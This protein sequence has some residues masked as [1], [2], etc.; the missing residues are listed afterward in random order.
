MWH[1]AVITEL[2]DF[3]RASLAEPVTAHVVEEPQV[4]RRRRVVAGLGY[5]VGTIALAATLR[6]EAGDELFYPAALGLAAIW[7]VGA[8]LAGP[9]RLGSARTRAGGVTTPVIQPFALGALLVVLFLAGAAVVAGIP[10]LREPVDDLLDHARYGSL[11]IVLALTLLNGVVEEL[12]FR[13][14][15]F[16]AFAPRHAVAGTT[17]LYTLTTIGSGVPLLVLAAAVLGFV[18]A[19]QRR[20]TGGVLAPI[21]THIT[22]STGMLLLLPTVLQISR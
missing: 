15:L 5:A 20:V 1:A 6:I 10:L 21:I 8:L 13:G 17:V 4:L 19:L 7:G 18:T 3:L 12:Y 9:L 2:R 16:S 11:P 14:A 22:W